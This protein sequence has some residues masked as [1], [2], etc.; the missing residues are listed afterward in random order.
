VADKV[1]VLRS[2]RKEVDERSFRIKYAELLNPSQLAAVT[3]KAAS[4]RARSC[5]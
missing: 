4:R 1:I 2:A 3:S 5:C